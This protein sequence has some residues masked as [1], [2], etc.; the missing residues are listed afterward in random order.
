M[1]YLLKKNI[2]RFALELK[3]E[4]PRRLMDRQKNRP[5]IFTP[6]DRKI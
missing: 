6:E 3:K 5:K 1:N 2:F 4:L